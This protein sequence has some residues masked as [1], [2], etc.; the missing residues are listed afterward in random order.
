MLE[1]EMCHLPR[2][3]LNKVCDPISQLSN[4]YFTHCSYNN[5]NVKEE[6]FEDVKKKIRILANNMYNARALPRAYNGIIVLLNSLNLKCEIRAKKA[7]KS[8]RNR[9]KLTAT[10]SVPRI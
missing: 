6:Y 3:V 10:S 1:Y 4:F 7:T 9:K 2:K 5:S 8:E